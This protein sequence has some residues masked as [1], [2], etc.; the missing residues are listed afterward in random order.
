[1]TS[2]VELESPHSLTRAL[3]SYASPAECEESVRRKSGR[4]RVEDR[5]TD[6]V[7]LPLCLA[8]VSPVLAG[9]GGAGGGREK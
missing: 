4:K 2:R 5:G 3:V 7:M 1:M 8:C 9:R 6:T